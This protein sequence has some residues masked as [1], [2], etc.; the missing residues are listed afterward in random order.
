MIAAARR[1]GR[2]GPLRMSASSS[3]S[4]RR[5]PAKAPRRPPRASARASPM[6]RLATCSAPPSR[7]G[8]PLGIEASRYME[9]GQLVPDDITI[10]MLLDRLAAAGC[11][12]RRHPRRLPADRGPGRGP[13]WAL[14]ER[15]ATRRPRAQ[16]RRADRRTWSTG[17]PGRRVCA[18]AG[19]PYHETANPPRGA[20]RLRPGRLAAGPARRRQAPR[21]SGRGWPSAARPLRDVVDYYRATGV[22]RPVDGLARSTMSVRA[23]SAAARPMAPSAR[24]DGHPQVEGRDRTH[25]PRRAGRGRGARAHRGRISGRVS[26]PPISTPRRGPHPAVRRDALVQGLPGHQPGRPFPAS[27]C[28][29]IDDEIVHGIPGE[30]TIR[31]G[32]VVS[33]DAGAIVEGWHGDGARTFFV[34]DPP[35]GIA[36]AHR[37]DPRWR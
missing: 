15:G 31:D 34:G 30:R 29:C 22:L 21:P 18:A 25:A 16:H 23:A 1:F 13:R 17:C 8:S 28:I 33:V 4:G 26:P 3:C 10:R 12:Q 32:Q 19:H 5:A 35:A 11:G 27:I 2:V 9:R 7:D 24:S 6:S 14:A 37:P 36:R 20:G